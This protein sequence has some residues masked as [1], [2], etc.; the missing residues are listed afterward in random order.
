[1]FQAD[2][3]AAKPFCLSLITVL[4]NT[5]GTIVRIENN[6]AFFAFKVDR[7]ASG[8]PNQL[9]FLLKAFSYFLIPGVEYSGVLCTD[10]WQVIQRYPIGDR[11]WRIL[12]SNG[13]IGRD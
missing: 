1:M 12:V 9:G 3:S 4:L 8:N 7:L 5:N 10:S 2:R 6:R 11:R 13:R